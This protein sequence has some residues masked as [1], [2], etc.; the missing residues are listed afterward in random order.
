MS[1]LDNLTAPPAASEPPAGPLDGIES[2]A[3]GAVQD[4]PSASVEAPPEHLLDASAEAAPEHLP[5]APAEASPSAAAP[6]SAL[7]APAAG[8]EMPAAAP[9]LES[10]PEQSA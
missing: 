1:I 10:P 5:D 3:E 7:S 4:L 8:E 6:T 2:P 9:G